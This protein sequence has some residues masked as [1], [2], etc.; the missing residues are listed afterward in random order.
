MTPRNR[1]H[2]H[3]TLQGLA[4][5]GEAN[6]AASVAALVGQRD[7]LEVLELGQRN[8]KCLQF[9]KMTAASFDA[10]TDAEG[11][12]KLAEHARLGDV[13]VF[14]SHSFHDPA[15][16]KWDALS[17]WAA[18]FGQLEGRKPTMWRDKFCIDQDN[19][20]ENLSAL[21]VFLSG[22]REMIVLMGSSYLSRLWQAPHHAP[23]VRKAYTDRLTVAAH[24]EAFTQ[25]HRCIIELYTF[26][27]MG[28]S[29]EL[30]SVSSCWPLSATVRRS[31][32][33]AHTSHSNHGCT[34]CHGLTRN[35]YSL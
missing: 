16:A 5:A 15:K 25:T 9:D 19:I 32:R 12:S 17:K 6:A 13:D 4:T 30:S 31:S 1:S 2:L 28:A 8:F 11:L 35:S 23:C 33:C 22:T 26:L 18:E 21:P 14:I 3:G 10:S 27:A 7:V 34:R 29:V 20:D 24:H